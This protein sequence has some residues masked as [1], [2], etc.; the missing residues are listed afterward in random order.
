MSGLVGKS[1]RHVLSCR[2]SFVFIQ[3][4]SWSRNEQFTYSMMQIYK[5]VGHKVTLVCSKVLLTDNSDHGAT[6]LNKTGIISR[7][8]GMHIMT[9]HL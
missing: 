6:T 7:F 9:V 4:I 1:R 5:H 8:S 3:G 2:G